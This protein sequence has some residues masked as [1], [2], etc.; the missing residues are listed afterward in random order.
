MRACRWVAPGSH[1]QPASPPAAFEG[2]LTRI[3][4]P[5]GGAILFHPLLVHAGGDA[6]CPPRVHS[7]ALLAKDRVRSP[8]SPIATYVGKQGGSPVNLSRLP[9]PTRGDFGDAAVRE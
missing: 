8:V 9:T 5:V 3:D 7:Y 4:L 2:R 6:S 1:L